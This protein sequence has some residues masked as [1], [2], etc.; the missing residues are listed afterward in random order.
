MIMAIADQIITAIFGKHPRFIR[1]VVHPDYFSVEFA[2]EIFAMY[3]DMVKIP[4][5]RNYSGKVSV[6]IAQNSMDRISIPLS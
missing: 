1:I 6:I 4:G 5:I 2:S 3:M